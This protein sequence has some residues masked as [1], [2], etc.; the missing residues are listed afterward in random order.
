MSQTLIQV[1]ELVARREVRVSDH[2]YDELAHDNIFVGDILAGVPEA[3]VVEDYPDFGK[4]PC[5][6]VLQRDADGKPIHVV[7]GIAKHTTSPAVVVTAYRPD[8]NRWSNDFL[9]RTP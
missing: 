5:V 9:R 4:G 7:W 6:L 2:G 3:A 8:L 1:R